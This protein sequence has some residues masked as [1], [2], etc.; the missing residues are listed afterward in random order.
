M[1]SIRAI[2]RR[3]ERFLRDA[4]VENAQLRVEFGPERFSLS[5]SLFL[6]VQAVSRI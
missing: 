2:E 4:R 5:L 1:R 6:R 3:G